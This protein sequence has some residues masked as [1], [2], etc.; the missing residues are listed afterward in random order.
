MSPFQEVRMANVNWL[1]LASVGCYGNVELAV[2]YRYNPETDLSFSFI[3]P[4]L[5]TLSPV[6][7]KPQTLP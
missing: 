4:L 5:T 7:P 1:R 6:N 2:I 3:N